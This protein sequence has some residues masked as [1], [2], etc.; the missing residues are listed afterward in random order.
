MKYILLILPL[1]FVSCITIRQTR[2][3]FTIYSEMPV[4]ICY[5]NKV[6]QIKDLLYMTQT[7]NIA[8]P[9]INKKGDYV[10]RIY[11]A[12]T[13]YATYHSLI[14]KSGELCQDKMD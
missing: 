8:L 13:S 2:A 9:Y 3:D 1:L 12:S 10:L 7:Y 5:I 14:L 6:P 4:D 11:H